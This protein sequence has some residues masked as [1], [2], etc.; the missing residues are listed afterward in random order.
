M[1]ADDERGSVSRHLEAFKADD[2]AA[3][4]AL[5]DRY[6]DRLTRLAHRRLGDLPRSVADS[7][8][9]AVSVFTSLCR[10]AAAGRFPQLNDRDDLWRVLLVLTRQKVAD[11]AR[12]QG[13]QKRGGGE[14]ARRTVSQRED[15]T[16]VE[17][18][19]LVGDEP[20]PELLVELDEEYRSRLNELRDDT[21]RRIACLRMESHTV[22]EIAE[23]LGISPRSVERK[24]GLIRD[25]WLPTLKGDFE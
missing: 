6:F 15:G 20:T 25:A 14:S 24:L 22:P 3:A 2:S 16:P 19:Q 1:T 11:Q 23:S 21:L 12:Y 7:E 4:Q 10:G 8:D 9:V 17:L 13:R 18:D 5:W